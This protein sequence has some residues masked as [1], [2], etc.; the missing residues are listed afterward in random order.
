MYQK[1]KVKR[2]HFEI[3]RTSI[4]TL[5]IQRRWWLKPNCIPERAR[6]RRWSNWTVGRLATFDKQVVTHPLNVKMISN[7]QN[8]RRNKRTGEGEVE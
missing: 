6:L 5:D 2:E 1:G 7:R 8:E 3:T 4:R